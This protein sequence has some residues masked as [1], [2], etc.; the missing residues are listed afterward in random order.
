MRPLNLDWNYN[1]LLCLY[2]EKKYE[3]DPGSLEGKYKDW[4]KK[5]HPD[6]VHNKSKVSLCFYILFYSS[7][8]KNELLRFEL[9][10]ERTRLRSR[11]VCEGD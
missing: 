11:A 6:L 7:F 2:R 8:L 9:L 4:Q 1:N 10:T 5:L 3:I